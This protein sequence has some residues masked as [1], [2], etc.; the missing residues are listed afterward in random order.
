MEKHI[1]IG[2]MGLGTVGT[3]VFKLLNDGVEED[4]ALEENNQYSIEKVLVAHPEKSRE[5]EVKKKKITD[6][7]DE[8]LDDP[9]LDVIIELIGGVKPARQYISRALAAKKHVI[10]ANK[11]LLARHG[12]ELLE[13]AA[14]NGV[15][16]LFS[17]SVAGGVPVIENLKRVTGTD[18]VEE[19][20][21]VINGTTNYILSQMAREE[22]DFDDVLARAQKLGYAEADP[23]SD[24]TGRDAVYKLTILASLVFGGWIDWDK[25]PRTGIENIPAEDH[26]FA[27]ELGYAF[28]LF[29]LARQQEK[30]LELR[31]QPTMIPRGKLLADVEGVNNAVKIVSPLHDNLTFAGPGAG[32][33]PTANTVVND[34]LS[35]YEKDLE[36]GL[37]KL[38]EKALNG[39]SLLGRDEFVS[40]Y[41]LRWSLEEPEKKKEK[42]EEFFAEDDLALIKAAALNSGISGL[43]AVTD[44]CKTGKLENLLEDMQEKTELP[45]PASV[46]RVR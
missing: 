7:P 5:V 44:S 3:G 25:I 17:A 31:V 13:K 45:G 26:Q 2:L 9:G 24:I 11:D 1:S 18:R 30:G 43:A 46:Y 16:L 29:A 12:D 33:F 27:D 32:R 6:N 8:L 4:L 10:T 15:K 41:Y 14:E 37:E 39:S 36:A 28:K 42:L 23:S 40:R 38:Q 35:L 19:I 21:G 20:A 34:L 22:A